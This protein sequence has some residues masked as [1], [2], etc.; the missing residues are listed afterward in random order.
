[1]DFFVQYTIHIIL[2]STCSTFLEYKPKPLL[3]SNKEYYID[4]RTARYA[5]DDRF[6]R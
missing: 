2:D 3:F 1:M 6:C 4:R 5:S